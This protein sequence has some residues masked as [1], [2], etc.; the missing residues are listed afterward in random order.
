MFSREFIITAGLSLALSTV[1]IEQGLAQSTHNH[2]TNSHAGHHNH[3][4]LLSL[5]EGPNAPNLEIEVVKDTVG[6]WNLHI[7]VENFEFAPQNVNEAHV[8]KEGHA[9]IYINGKKLARIYAPWFHISALPA[10]N[11]EVRV[12]LNANDHR[13]LSVGEKP[14]SATKHVLVK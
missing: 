9:H 5:P 7:I 13:A 1:F 6:G 4:K 11:V 14:L 3:D 12:S 2:D 8:A 10:G